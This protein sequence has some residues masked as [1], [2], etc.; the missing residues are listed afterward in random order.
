M[1]DPW[2]PSPRR[3]GPDRR[4]RARHD[5]VPDRRALRVLGR[6][7][8]GH[9]QSAGR[10]KSGRTRPGPRWLTAQL[11]ECARAAVRT[12]EHLPRRALRSAPRTPWRAESD[13]RDPPRPA[14]RLL[15]H[16]PRPSPIPRPRTGLAT[17]ALLGRA[18]RPPT[19]TPTRSTR[20]H[21]HA[22]ADRTRRTSRL[23]FENPS[24]PPAR[25]SRRKRP[26]PNVIAT[27]G[28]TGQSP[29]CATACRAGLPAT[30]EA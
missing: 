21:R 24:C 19:P 14:R 16:R 5:R 2:R 23:T 12:K 15:P 20:L 22:R 28:F 29:V 7:V 11:T 8:P 25:H 6:R 26:C 3:P 10:R 4:M 17:Q 30:H 1:H 13:R 9:H 27:R 18:P